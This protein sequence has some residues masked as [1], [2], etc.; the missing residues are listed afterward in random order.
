MSEA[1]DLVLPPLFQARA[2]SGAAAPFAEACR[3]A[4]EGCDSGLVLHRV[5]DGSLRAAIVFAPEVPLRQAMAA[6]VACGV[7]FQNALGA[8]APPEVS[9]MLAWDGGILLN[10][11]TCGRLCAAASAADPAAE[12]DWLVV[13][14]E[15]SLIP[16]PESDPGATPDRTC[17]FEEGCAEVDPVTLLEAWV[18]H[19]LVHI[20]DL[21]ESGHRG[22]HDEW[23]G[24]AEGIGAEI[25][26]HLQGR[27]AT[28]IFVG[29]D[30][31]FGML[32]RRGDRTELV[33]LTDILERGESA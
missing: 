9:V 27:E 13:G 30:E 16:P 14:L 20:S 22:L 28:G 1:A 4:A 12:P 11:A 24:L 29:V 18:R 31:D 3:L 17:L 8:L 26:V 33:P 2:V 10:G 19:T 15:L 23:K 7:G 6:F 25:S 5:G 21:A 32:L